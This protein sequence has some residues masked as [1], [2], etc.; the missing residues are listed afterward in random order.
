[1]RQAPVAVV[2]ALALLGACGGGGSGGGGGPARLPVLPKGDFVFFSTAVF[3]TPGNEAEALRRAARL[4]WIK[5]F[6]ICLTNGYQN[7]AGK[8]LQEL[9]A[10]G[11]E[12]FIYRWFNGFYRVELLP[13]DA[14]AESRAYYAQFPGMVELF[15]QIHAHPEWLLNP[16]LPIQGGGAA[17]P[18]YFYDYANAEFRRFFETAIRRDLD[19][20]QY[21]GVFFDYIGGWA[22]PPEIDEI[23][24]ARHPGTTYDV[25]GITFL[26]E[27][28][29]AIGAKRIFGN[30]A[31]RLPEGYYDVIDYDASESLATSFVW[32]KEAVLQME[33]SGPQNVLDT[34][35]RSWDGPGGYREAARE[36]LAAAARGSR[37]R[38]CDINYLQ[39][40]RVPTGET[41]EAGG[42]RVPVFTQRTDRPAI[43]YSYAI[44]KLAGGYAFA[45]DWYAEGFG[46]DDVYFLDLGEPLHSQYVETSG[47]VVRYYKNGFVLVTRSNQPLVFQPDAGFLPAGVAEVWDVYEGTS[48]HGWSTRRAVSVV[49]AYYASTESYYP[50]GRVYAYLNS[51]SAK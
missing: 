12:L 47:A 46:E 9:R 13:D 50:S 40:W 45:S 49:P 21:D 35:Y 8:D 44:S 25:A 4:E 20:A 28:R 1:M 24:Q 34:F 26:T 33:G 15:R 38:V 2:L 27:L 22:L 39:P 10:A 14:P 3:Q 42:R 7:F 36:R 5:R 30:Q 51:M 29:A 43:F 31:Y 23:W 37:A 19:G 32:G 18:A 48:V 17:Y 16:D 6:R 41:V 11:S